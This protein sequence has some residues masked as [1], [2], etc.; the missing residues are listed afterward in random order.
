M[1]VQ[2]RMELI[3]SWLADHFTDDTIANL[4]CLM[5]EVRKTLSYVLPHQVLLV[6]N[7]TGNPL[8][9]GTLG[10]HKVNIYHTFEVS[11]R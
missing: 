3:G 8:P 4:T 1:G 2:D 9:F 10:V 11:Q 7:K 6:D 5:L